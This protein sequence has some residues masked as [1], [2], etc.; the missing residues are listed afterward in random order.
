MP[1]STG[2]KAR[3]AGR[4]D[5]VIPNSLTHFCAVLA[6]PRSPFN[7]RGEYASDRY[8]NGSDRGDFRVYIN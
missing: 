6:F 2:E 7:L 3:S 5:Q 8:G 1:A 4:K